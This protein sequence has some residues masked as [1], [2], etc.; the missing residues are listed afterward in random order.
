MLPPSTKHLSINYQV[1]VERNR[2]TPRNCAGT[3]YL[4]FV[5]GTGTS[6]G[7]GILAGEK[8]ENVKFP[9]LILSLSK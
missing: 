2:C 1:G 8:P 6:T 3:G 5:F 9:G 7:T 4:A